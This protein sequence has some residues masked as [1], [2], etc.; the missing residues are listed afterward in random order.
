[1]PS[2]ADDDFTIN[3]F[4]YGRFH[5]VQPR[6]GGH[7]AGTDA[8][9]LAAAVSSSFAGRLVDLGAGAGAAALAVLA[10]CA[11]ATAVLAERSPAMAECAARSLA[12][13]ANAF[14]RDRAR[15]LV[16]DVALA[17][18]ARDA[19]LPDH[20]FDFAIMNPPFNEARDRATPA[21]LKRQAHVMEDGLLDDWMRSAAA[22]VKPGGG[23]AAIVRPQSLATLLAAVGGRFG[24]AQIVPVHPRPGT[25]AI[26]IVLRAV[27]GSRA[28]L[29]L[30]PPLMLHEVSGAGFTDRAEAIHAGRA[31]LFDD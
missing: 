27:R 17:G 16:A 2:S 26:R 4:H 9:L 21:P 11:S 8:I 29:A 13:P 6:R 1:M 30:L 3:A 10:R 18:S 28:R 22:V 23:V 25:P 14:L 19:G 31:T 20:A 15:V 5:L 12:L 24:A 7:R